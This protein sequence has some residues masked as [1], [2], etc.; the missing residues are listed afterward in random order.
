MSSRLNSTSHTGTY[1]QLYSAACAGFAWTRRTAA[2]G[3]Y[4]V[5]WVILAFALML[6]MGLVVDGGG[7]LSARQYAN[8]VAEEAA[9]TA[10]QQVIRPLGMRGIAAVSDPVT[11]QIAAQAYLALHPDVHGVVIPTGLTT[12]TVV[13]T[14]VYQPKILSL[15]GA[16]PQT[17]T[18]R[19]VITLNRTNNGAVGLP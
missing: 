2:R 14:V 17:V 3:S 10:G 18:G 8:H 15:Y 12:L 13:V 19:A 16:G 9:R 11:A 1:A 5:F 6:G 4:L 7:K